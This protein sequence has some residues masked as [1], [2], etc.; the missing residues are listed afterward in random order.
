MDDR[1]NPRGLIEAFG[2]LPEA[3]RSTHQLV[4][5]CALSNED[6]ERLWRLAASVGAGDALVTTGEVSDDVLRVLYQRCAAFVFPSIYEGFGLP[7]LEAMHCG[8][9]VLAGNNSSQ[10]EVV[11]EAGLVANVADGGDIAAKLTRILVEPGLAADLRERAIVRARSFSWPA[12]AAVAKT[13]LHNVTSRATPAATVPTTARVRSRKP[14]IA[15]FSPLPPRRTGIADYARFLLD[16]LKQTYAIDLYHQSGYV[17]EPALASDEF[18]AR[19][20][21]LFRRFAAAE[22]YHGA[23]YQ[24]GNSRHHFDVYESLLGYP[25]VVTLHDLGLAGFHA[26]YAQ[27]RGLG[28]GGI[29]DELLRWYPDAAAE[30]DAPLRLAGGDPGVLVA[31]CVRNG[32]H[33]NQRILT[34]SRCVVVHSP[35]CIEVLRAMGSVENVVVIPHG[36]RPRSLSEAKRFAIRDRFAIARDALVVASFGSLHV[37]KMNCETVLAFRELAAVCPKAIMLFVGE[38]EDGGLT[39]REVGRLGMVDR[40]RFL[41]R[42]TTSDFADLAA[43][44]DVGV[45]LRMPPTNGETSGALLTLLAAGV[46]TVVTDVGSFSD[47]PDHVVRKVRWDVAEAVGL[48]RALLDLARDDETRAGLGRSAWTYVSEYH[49][50]SRIGSMYVDA[51]EA[52][53]RAGRRRSTRQAV[54]SLSPC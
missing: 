48:E 31:E 49:D 8:A 9:P 7:I 36:V 32:W 35:W 42:T 29:R 25:G 1:K 50:W 20:T 45:N 30:I 14:R 13:T 40:I 2:R 4:I 28:F 54:V 3:L 24:M 37:S 38:E 27:S 51:I 19:D 23:V 34:A 18:R 52:A 22:N 17:P 10:P 26:Q 15:F 44:T 12:T 6:R 47:Y 53:H 43:V 11:G 5:A 46:P 41:G 39:R 16:E 21:R 33:L